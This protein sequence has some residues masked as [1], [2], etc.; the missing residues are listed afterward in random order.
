MSAVY[1]SAFLSA[2]CLISASRNSFVSLI[3][4]MYRWYWHLWPSHLQQHSSLY[5]VKTW[6]WK[7]AGGEWKWDVCSIFL[8]LPTDKCLLVYWIPTQNEVTSSEWLSHQPRKQSVFPPSNES[9]YMTV[10]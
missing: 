5:M 7:H 6:R 3:L 4:A 8:E 2:P 10:V 1:F 9:T